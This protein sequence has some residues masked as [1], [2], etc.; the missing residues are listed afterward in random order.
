M[1][2][3]ILRYGVQLIRQNVLLSCGLC[4]FACQVG[5]GL[6]GEPGVQGGCDVDVYTN[7]VIEEKKKEKIRKLN[8]HYVT[9]CY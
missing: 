2:S 1:G 8:L 6:G 9:E 5:R 4:H 3:T 7:N